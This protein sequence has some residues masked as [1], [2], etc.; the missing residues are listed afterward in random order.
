M[1]SVIVLA[2]KDLRIL[3]RVRSGLFFTFVWPVIVAVM[4][5]V[6][7]AGQGQ[8]GRSPLRVV[9]VDEDKTAE[10]REYIARLVAS[11]DFAVEE[12]TRAEA[13]N[14]VRRGQRSAFA[15]IKPG[16]GDGSR[17]MFYGAARQIELGSD[18]SRAAEAGMIEGLLT[19]YAMEDMRKLRHELRDWSGQ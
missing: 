5:G 14:M 1:R 16:F 7:F 11:G 8:G 19:K 12:G 9:V 4:F 13:E 17:R 10:S 2:L 6:V 15:V 3:V 18:P